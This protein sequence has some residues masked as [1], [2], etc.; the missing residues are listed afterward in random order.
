MY[1]YIYIS[2]SLYIYILKAPAQSKTFPSVAE[3][4]VEDERSVG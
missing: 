2:L 3:G 1:I 4:R